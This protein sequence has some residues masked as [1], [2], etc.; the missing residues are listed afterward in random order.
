MRCE[1]YTSGCKAVFRKYAAQ[2]QRIRAA[3][4]QHIARQVA[5]NF[6]QTKLASR[7]LFEGLS[8]YECR[9]NVGKLPAFRVAFTVRADLATVVYIS[10]HIQKSEFS[11]EI[12][13]FL[14]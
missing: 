14:K 9:V 4:A 2:E 6:A 8:V 13:A 11:R 1:F 5:T 10:T 3:I 7:R 12:D